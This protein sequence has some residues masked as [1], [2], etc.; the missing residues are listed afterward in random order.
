MNE[1]EGIPAELP[2]SIGL[3]IRNAVR[4]THE[5]SIQNRWQADTR[6]IGDEVALISTELGELMEKY[7]DWWEPNEIRV[8]DHFEGGIQYRGIPMELADVVI[9]CFDMAQR[10]EIDLESAVAEKI[11]FNKTRTTK[12]GGKRI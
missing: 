4:Q 10:H 1:K 7:R 12:H 9:R 3:T 5:I 6:S 8:V 2:K 11:R